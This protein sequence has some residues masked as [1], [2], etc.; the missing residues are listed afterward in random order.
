[1]LANACE[2]FLV[3]LANEANPAVDLE[4][5]TGVISKADR[6]RAANVIAQK[7][8]G[9]MTF[10]GQLRNAADHGIDD[11]VNLDWAITPDSVRLGGFVL[12]GGIKSVV[13]L[14]EGRAEF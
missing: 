2:N 4:G 10:I 9:F 14:T 6:L 1:M 13:A 5:A 12:L 11:E 7:Q 8:M 3:K